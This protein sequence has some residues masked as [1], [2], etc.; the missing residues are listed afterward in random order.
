MQIF[1][2]SG[3]GLDILIKEFEDYITFLIWAAWVCLFFTLSKNKN[4]QSEPLL[5]IPSSSP[6]M[7]EFVQ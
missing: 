6:S 1:S 4:F 7:K 2:T 3:I 5:K